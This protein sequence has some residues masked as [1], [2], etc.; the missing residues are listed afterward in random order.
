MHCFTEAGDCLSIHRPIQYTHTRRLKTDTLFYLSQAEIQNLIGDVPSWLAFRDVERGGW[1]NK[2]L[3]AAWPYLNQ[4]TSGVI[5]AALDPILTATRPSFLT[6]LRFEKFSFGS[7]PA[8]IEGTA[9]R[10]S[11]IRGHTVCRLAR[12]TV[13]SLSW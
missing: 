6:A 11:Q 9:L 5:V 1:L 12:H 8:K 3:Q 10:V 13:L 4:A 7:V 2:V